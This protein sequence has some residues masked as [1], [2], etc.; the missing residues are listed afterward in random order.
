MAASAAEPEAGFMRRILTAIVLIPAVVAL[1]LF[2]TPYLL[3][4]VQFAIA[5]T[6]LWEFLRLAE[7]AGFHVL[8]TSGCLFAAALS[9]LPLTESPGLGIVAVSMFFLMVMMV[10]AMRPGQGVSQFFG[11][12][13][14]SFFGPIYIAVP[15]M[16]L[17]WVWLNYDGPY[18]VLF[19]LVVIWSGDT[20]AFFVGRSLGRHKCSPRISPNKTWEGVAASLAAS[21]LVA[22][23]AGLWFAG[24]DFW[25]EPLPLAAALN[26][27]GQFGDLAESALKRNAGVKDSSQLIPGHGGVLDRIDA[28][29]FAA[30]VLWYYWLWQAPFVR[31]W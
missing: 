26:V 21:L 12:V 2:G 31:P 16:M 9:F 20:A 24:T 3:V 25:W 28:L 4:A 5:L 17:V 18:H 11:S 10:V 22:V 23:A 27:A 14:V 30:P 8:R 6:A 19:A 15:L 13:A 7:V 1:V 29:L